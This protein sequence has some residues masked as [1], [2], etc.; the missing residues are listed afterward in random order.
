MKF[1][2]AASSALTAGTSGEVW[3]DAPK[4]ALSRPNAFSEFRK[5]GIVGLELLDEIFLRAHDTGQAVDRGQFVLERLR[6]GAQL[7]QRQ[8][9]VAG[10]LHKGS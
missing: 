7:V 2:M 3:S 10:V 9:K 8:I 1:S 6:G 4:A 5:H